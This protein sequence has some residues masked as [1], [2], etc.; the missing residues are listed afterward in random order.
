MMQQLH[1][2]QQC[3]AALKAMAVAGRMTWMTCSWSSRSYSSSSSQ[4]GQQQQALVLQAGIL[5]AVGMM[6]WMTCSWSS[7]SFSSS[8]SSSPAGRLQHQAAQ[9][10]LAVQGM[11]L[12]LLL[13]LTPS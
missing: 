2:Q 4:A 1:Q 3:Q 7:R 5:V 8:S 12:L 13:T 11:P 10:Q 9:Q 6:S